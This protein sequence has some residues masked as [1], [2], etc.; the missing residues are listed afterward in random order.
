MTWEEDL[1]RLVPPPRSSLT[2]VDWVRVEESVG[3]R[4][5]SDYKWLAERYGPGS[6][7]EFLHVFQPGYR[8]EALNLEFQ[9]GRTE[10]TMDHLRRAGEVI[11]YQNA[12]LLACFRTDNG[13]TG[14]LV[15]RPVDQPD[16]WTI[17]I[18][19]ARGTRWSTFDGGIVQF[20]QMVLSSRYRVVVFPD[21]FPSSQ[22]GFARY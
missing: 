16:A 20:L 11:P 8:S 5:P 9:V 12:E 22:P 18:N 3:T 2:G 14:Y 19:E 10:L 21:D 15:R 4:L 17:V 7:D 6:F 13:D 1:V